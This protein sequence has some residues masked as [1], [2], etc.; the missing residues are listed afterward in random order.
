VVITNSSLFNTTPSLS[1]TLM[2]HFGMPANTINYNLGGMGCSGGCRDMRGGGAFR[3]RLVGLASSSAEA[4]RASPP[5]PPPPVPTPLRRRRRRPPAA[6][7]IATDLARQLL[8]IYPNT[9]ALVVSTENLTYNWYPG[10]NRGMLVTNT[11]FRV[12]GAAM[13]FSNKAKD[14]WWGPGRGSRGLGAASSWARGRRAAAAPGLRLPHG[15]RGRALEDGGPTPQ[16]GRPQHA[17]VAAQSPAPP[18][19]PRAH[20][21]ARARPPPPPLKAVQVRAAARGAHQPG[22]QR[23]RLQLRAR[24]GGRVRRARHPPGQGADER[25]RWGGR[26][27]GGEGEGRER[28]GSGREGGLPAR[29]RARAWPNRPDGPRPRAR[30]SPPGVAPHACCPPP[31]PRHTP[32]YTPPPLPQAWP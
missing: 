7:V 4:A 15:C 21:P 19:L 16:H 22:R 8:T 6:G 32:L 30:G 14:S 12:G 25:R 1:A 29:G 24:G 27:G 5:S 23:H 17:E 3:T 2:N 28:R 9:Y 13:L 11:I 31:H 18:A 20:P 26:G 10:T